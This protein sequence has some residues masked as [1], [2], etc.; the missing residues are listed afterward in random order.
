M[1]PGSALAA[2]RAAADSCTTDGVDFTDEQRADGMALFDE[3][4][5]LFANAGRP[6]RRAGGAM[7]IV[8]ER[9]AS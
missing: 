1:G 5:A 8:A 6:V 7:P 4:R 9:S 3:L 2:L